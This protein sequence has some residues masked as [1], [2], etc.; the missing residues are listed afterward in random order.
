MLFFSI[1]L[2]HILLV[3]MRHFTT[4]HVKHIYHDILYFTTFQ[5]KNVSLKVPYLITFP[6]RNVSHN[7]L[8]LITF[9][10]LINGS[11]NVLF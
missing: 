5:V 11:N 2:F 8:Y 9:P 7:I 10:S 1:S 4:S 6:V 3:V